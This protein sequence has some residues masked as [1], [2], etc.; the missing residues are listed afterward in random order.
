[1]MITSNKNLK[2]VKIKIMMTK[3]Q[4]MVKKKMRSKTN[5]K[6]VKKKI[7]KNNKIKKEVIIIIKQIT[8][9]VILLKNNQLRLIKMNK[10]PTQMIIVLTKMQDAFS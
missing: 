1:M 8:T 4:K 2:K 7:K 6:T 3:T 9:R 10:W 5:K